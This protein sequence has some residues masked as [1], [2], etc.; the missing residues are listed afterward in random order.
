MKGLSREIDQL[1]DTLQIIKDLIGLLARLSLLAVK[2]SQ[3]TRAASVQPEARVFLA[4][5]LCK[6]SG[7]GFRCSFVVRRIGRV[8]SSPLSNQWIEKKTPCW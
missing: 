8:W 4:V 7:D 2:V 6:T 3:D 5:T 1:I